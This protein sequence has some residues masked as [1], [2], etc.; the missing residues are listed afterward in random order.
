MA[1]S[2]SDQFVRD[3]FGSG[4]SMTTE[5]GKRYERDEDPYDD[6]ARRDRKTD[7]AGTDG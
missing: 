2:Q 6:M 1:T 5:H 3:R 7:G 4:T